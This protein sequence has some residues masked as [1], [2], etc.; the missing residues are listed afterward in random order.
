MR[1]PVTKFT[2]YIRRR[3]KGKVTGGVISTVLV[4]GLALGL[5]TAFLAAAPAAAL[6]VLGTVAF[7]M[8]LLFGAMEDDAGCKKNHLYINGYELVGP[9]KYMSRIY[10]VQRILNKY[11]DKRSH[12]IVLPKSIERKLMRHVRDAEKAVRMVRIYKSGKEVD[13]FDFMRKVYNEK[14]R[15]EDRI[16]ATVSASKKAAVAEPVE[17]PKAE[18]AP[19]APL[20]TE[21]KPEAGIQKE[22]FNKLS[23]TVQQLK[24]DVDQINNPPPV[25]EIRKSD[26]FLNRRG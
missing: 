26:V 9:P 20:P 13:R 25:V 2:R 7:G 5:P 10:S 18:K 16:F 12:L 15:N 3:H 17:K 6:G 1:N 24:K 22:E 21:K 19:P 11:L 14:G 4:G 23:E 8:P